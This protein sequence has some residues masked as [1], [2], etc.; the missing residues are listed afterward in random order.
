M[1]SKKGKCDDADEEEDES[2]IR[3]VKTQLKNILLPGENRDILIAAITE[4]SIIATEICHLASLLFLYRVEQAFDDRHDEFFRQNGDDV[5]RQCF[6]AVCE[7]NFNK[8][9]VEFRAFAAENGIQWPS[10]AFVG[11]GV[12]DLI[13]TYTTNVK[14]NLKV[15]QAKRLKQ[16]LLA[17]VYILNNSNPVVVRYTQKDIDN[18]VD[19]AIYGQDSIETKDIESVCERTRRNMLLDMVLAESWF[20]IPYKKIGLFTKR[21]WFKSIQFWISLQRKID[22]FNTTEDQKEERKIKRA[23]YREMMRCRRRNHR[24][25]CT[26]KEQEPQAEGETSKKGPPQVRNLAVIPICSFTRT[27]YT[28]DS[29]TLWSL[30]CQTDINPLVSNGKRGKPP[31]LISRKEFMSKEKVNNVE[32][33]RSIGAKFSTCKKSIGWCDA[34]KR[35]V[36]AFCRMVKLRQYCLMWMKSIVVNSTKK[37]LLAN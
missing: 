3:T 7:K 31:R 36:S 25:T 11:N 35:S 13:I 26:C 5:I 20:D 12:N 22:V 2:K 28:L 15:H 33:N 1:A 17:K 34:K 21:D 14:N 27:H 18:V 4:K 24:P 6:Q 29:S 8:I 19:L 9:D 32:K 16:Y 23:E 10:N 37:S 30:L